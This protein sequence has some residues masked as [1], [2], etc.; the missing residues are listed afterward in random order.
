MART[1]LAIQFKIDQIKGDKRINIRSNIT[2]GDLITAIQKQFSLDGL[3]E[4]KLGN[5]LLDPALP[6][7]EQGVADQGRLLFSAT[8]MKRS[9]T[10]DLIVRGVR[11]EFSV[12]KQR[13]F[14]SDDREGTEYDIYWQ[15]AVL[16]RRDP[17]DAFR[18]QLVAVD[19][20]EA[21]DS[22]S[23]SRH[24]AC[25]TEAAGQFYVEGLSDRNPTYVNDA[26]LRFGVKTLLHAGDRILMGRISLTFY[27]VD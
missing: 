15:P 6:L 21:G 25:I 22:M 2:A 13:V 7:D 27:V 18:N 19:L 5:R 24:H 23:V 12:P 14:V 9:D 17:R 26:P 3:Y 8:E 1:T 16:G 4:I 10:A 11:Q 20:E